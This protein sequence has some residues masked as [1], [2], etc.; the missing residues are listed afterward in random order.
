MD[1][2]VVSDGHYRDVEAFKVGRIGAQG[3]TRIV[4]V[5]CDLGAA[6]VVPE[7]VAANGRL[8]NRSPYP[9]QEVL[10]PEVEVGLIRAEVPEVR[11][12]IAVV[13]RCYRSD[14]ET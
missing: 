7:S 1:T 3:H 5:N 12:K 4:H 13:I 14:R 2:Y 10:Y 8:V 9:V 6:L 11:R